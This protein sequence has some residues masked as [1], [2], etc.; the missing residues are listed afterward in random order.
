M[1]CITKLAPNNIDLTKSHTWKHA[2]KSKYIPPK[3]YKNSSS[4]YKQSTKQP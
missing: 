3:N 2:Y 4:K 1:L